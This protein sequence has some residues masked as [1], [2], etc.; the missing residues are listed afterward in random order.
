LER[1]VKVPGGKTLM[2]KVT[3]QGDSVERL[4]ISGDFFFHPE[5]GLEELESFLLAE[6]VWETEDVE[7]VIGRFLEENGYRAVGFAPSDLAFLLR[8]IRC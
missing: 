5:E 8:G 1:R 3:C 4:R 6:R 7:G 2:L